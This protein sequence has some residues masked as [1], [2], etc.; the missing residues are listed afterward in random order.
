MKKLSLY[1]L[2]LTKHQKPEA[3]YFVNDWFIW[4]SISISIKRKAPL[5]N[6]SFCNS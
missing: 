1:L 6:Y 3:K 4:E 2:Q 5:A